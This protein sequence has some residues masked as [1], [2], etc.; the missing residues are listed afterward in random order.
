MAGRLT[1]KSPP[2]IL[3]Q[4]FA[5]IGYVEETGIAQNLRDAR[6]AMIYE[7]TNGIQAMDLISRKI[8]INDGA[9]FDDLYDDLLKLIS[10]SDYEEKI[11]KYLD[12]LKKHTNKMR[13]MVIDRDEKA[14]FIAA[15]YLKSFALIVG[16][17]MMAACQVKASALDSSKKSFAEDKLATVQFYIDYILPEANLFDHIG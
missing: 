2:T 15:Y 6:I 3:A 7:G 13:K 16:G 1:A 14:G 8:I 11:T 10:G 4:V 9:L 17:V 12:S 5:G